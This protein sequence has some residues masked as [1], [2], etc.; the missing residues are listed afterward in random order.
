MRTP[1]FRARAKR[2]LLLAS[3][4]GAGPF[5]ITLALFRRGAGRIL[6]RSG[7]EVGWVVSR[8]QKMGSAFISFQHIVRDGVGVSSP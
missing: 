2:W 6:K 7:V 1:A 3:G 5:G 8:H 4:K